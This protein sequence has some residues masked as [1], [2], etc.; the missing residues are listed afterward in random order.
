MKRLILII[1]MGMI[2]M[3]SFS[4][5]LMVQAYENPYENNPYSTWDEQ[6]QSQHDRWQ[7]QQREHDRQ[8]EEMER[9]NQQKQREYEHQKELDELKRQLEERSN[10]RTNWKYYQP[11]YL[12]STPSLAHIDAGDQTNE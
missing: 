10:P 8:R 1:T 5:P 9:Y 3:F 11:D 2:L 7:E 12:R 6:P 4:L